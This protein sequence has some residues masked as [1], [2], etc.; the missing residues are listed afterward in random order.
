MP[1][2]K[3]D[4]WLVDNKDRLMKNLILVEELCNMKVT[5]DPLLILQRY[6]VMHQPTQS[7]RIRKTMKNHILHQWKRLC[8]FPRNSGSSGEDNI[9]EIY[10]ENYK[11]MV[12]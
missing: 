6:N 11:N 8:R 4:R 1:I 7:K 12:R 3:N 2:N 9:A 10:K 5:E